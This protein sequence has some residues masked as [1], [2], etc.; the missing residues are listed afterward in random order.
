MSRVTVARFASWIVCG[1]VIAAPIRATTPTENRHADVD[2]PILAGEN[3]ALHYVGYEA[4]LIHVRTRNPEI[5]EIYLST[6]YRHYL[7]VCR[8]EGISL[9][10]ALA[11]MVHETDHLRFTG[12]VRAV[13]Y[14]YA[15]IGA[16]GP[17]HPGDTFADMR[18]GVIAHVQH[19]VAYASTEEPTGELIDPRFHLV[20][21]GSATTIHA[22]T[23][24][25][26]SDPEYGRKVLA[27]V[28]ALRRAAP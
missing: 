2:L 28:A 14:N 18:D 7:A 11:Q 5:D 1:L 22:L 9:I 17:G 26:A 3:H 20:R 6:L 19:L 10:A 24:R 4:L 23:G 21:R 27:H 16:I 8:V 12:S 15:G 13:Q 25:W